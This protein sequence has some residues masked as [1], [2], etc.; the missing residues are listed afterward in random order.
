MTNQLTRLG[1]EARVAER[2]P[3]ATQ[4]ATAARL[5]QAVID[6]VDY[7][8]FIDE[9]PLSTKIQGSSGFT[10]KF[11]AQGPKDS[12]GRSLREFN[13]EQRLM[14][15]P[16]S[17]MIYAPAFDALPPATRDAVYQ[18]MWNV[19]S[20]QEKGKRY[21]MLQVADRRAVI[22]ILRETKKNLPP[23]FQAAIQ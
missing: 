4:K 17:Y 11:V 23:F 3:A 12:R 18:R 1:W 13:L 15:Y 16:C 9:P 2:E 14:R 20:G 19:L 5:Q 8:L 10:E 21:S 6:F 7:L 22:E